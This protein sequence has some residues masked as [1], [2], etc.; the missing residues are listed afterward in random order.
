MSLLSVIPRS[1]KLWLKARWLAL[2]AR[3]VGI[4][5]S[6]DAA[7]LAATLRA[8]GIAPGDAVMLHSAFGGAHGFRGSIDELTRVFLD[9]VAPN[10]H[11]LMVTLPYRSSSLQYL[12]TLRK[13]DVR[14]TPSM[15]GLVS[16]YFRRR[17]DVLRSVHP[18]HPVVVHGPRAEWFVNEHP[19]C[20]H[21]CGPGSPFDKL[22]QADGKVAFFNVPFD[23][24]TFFHHLEHLVHDRLPFALYSDEAFEVPVIDRAG[25]RRV[26]T[27]Q[28]FAPD[29]I[30]RRRFP[31]LEAALRRRGLIREQRVGNS[32][33]Q[34][35]RV[36]DA[37]DCVM[38]MSRR[39]EYFYDL[40][41][42]QAADAP[43]A[44]P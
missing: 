13:F 4:F 27:T 35:I 3:F 18:T 16:E 44:I 22:A 1:P 24:F 29:A 19:A 32:R 10:G 6:Y 20:R 39:G 28:V 33:V 15:M 38:E 25:E 17:P 9:A 5:L 23:T 30:A 12:R 2:R 11:L 41:P 14:T 40:T 8:L 26:V 7:R 34:V 21:P 36:R 43:P 42:Q 37:I 31:I